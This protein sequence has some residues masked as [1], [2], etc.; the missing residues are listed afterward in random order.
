MGKEFQKRKSFMSCF[1]PCQHASTAPRLISAREPGPPHV[2][3]PSTLTT[4]THLSGPS[5]PKSSLAP[6]SRVI[7]GEFPIAEPSTCLFILTTVPPPVRLHPG[8]VVLPLVQRGVWSVV[9]SVL[10]PASCCTAQMPEP[11]ARRRGPHAARFAG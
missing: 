4:G 1:P 9:P 8:A 7:A 10:H 6:C 5:F 3:A 2:T 11:T